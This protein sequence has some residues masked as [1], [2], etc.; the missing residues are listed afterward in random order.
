MFSFGRKLDPGLAVICGTVS[1]G[2]DTIFFVAVFLRHPIIYMQQ[3]VN[4]S[5]EGN[6]YLRTTART[7]EGD[8]VA[9]RCEIMAANLG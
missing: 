5:A 8:L 9:N 3:R 1:A 6:V 4:E 2:P 7:N